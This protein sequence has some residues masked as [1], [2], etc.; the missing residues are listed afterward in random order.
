[1]DALLLFHVCLEGGGAEGERERWSREF[2]QGHITLL[3][4]HSRLCIAFL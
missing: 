3:S 1:M 4:P 2:T